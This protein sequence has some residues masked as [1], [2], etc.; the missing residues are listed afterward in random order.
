MDGWGANALLS[1]GCAC[2][3]FP[4]PRLWRVLAGRVQAAMMA[5]ASVE[6][7]LELARRLSVMRLPASLLP[8]ILQTA[9]QSFVD[10]VAPTDPNDMWSLVRYARGLQPTSVAD[11]I[12]AAATLD[13]PLVSIDQADAGNP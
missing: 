4:E 5:A 9:M 8:S 7:N 13:G 11:Y 2:T 12:A 6:M 1:F 3:H 10:T